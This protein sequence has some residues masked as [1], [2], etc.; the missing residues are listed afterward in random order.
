MCF[1][2]LLEAS[3]KHQH[4]WTGTVINTC[5]ISGIVK[6]AQHHFAYNA[7]KAAVIH[8]TK[9]L[10]CEIAD[11]NNLKVRINSIAPGEQLCE[12]CDWGQT[13]T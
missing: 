2:P 13:L 11:K 3:T 12:D 10:S 7:S 1:L 8:L 5:S 4:G 9:M 6:V